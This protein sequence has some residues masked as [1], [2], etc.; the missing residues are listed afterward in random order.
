MFFFHYNFYL[1]VYFYSN[2]HAYLPNSDN[3]HAVAQCISKLQLNRNPSHTLS[4]RSPKMSRGFRGHKTNAF[5]NA[6]DVY[7]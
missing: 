1:I 5:A 6:M 2:L 4:E 7:S 3:I